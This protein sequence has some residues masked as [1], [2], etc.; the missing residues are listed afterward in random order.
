MRLVEIGLGTVTIELSPEDAYLLARACTVADLK[1]EGSSAIPGDVTADLFAA[2]AAMG[3]D[4]YAGAMRYEALAALFDAASLAAV[5][6][7]HVGRDVGN[8]LTLANLREGNGRMLD[9]SVPTE[10]DEPSSAA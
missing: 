5:A 4:T 2:A 9:F 7:R 10:H 6:S 8:L 1:L 3:M